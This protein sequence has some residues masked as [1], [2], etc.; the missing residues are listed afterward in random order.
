MSLLATARRLRHGPLRP[1]SPLWVALGSLF[2]GALARSPWRLA[3][4]HKLGPY[5]PFRLDGHFAFSNFEGWGDVAHNRGYEACIE[6]ARGKFCMLDV[7]GHI[8][9]VSL[10]AASVLAPGGQ[11]FAFEPASANLHYL[12]R[13]IALNRI[14]NIEVIEALVGAE[15]LDG[16][17]FF[18]NPNPTGENSVLAR[19]GLRETTRPQITLDGFCAEQGLAP[20]V[21]KIDV[22]GAEIDVLRGAAETLKRHRPLV[23][24]SVHPRHLKQL[25]R[26]EA[27]LHTCIEALGYRCLDMDGQP[28]ERFALDEYRLVPKDESERD[29]A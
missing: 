21:V 8:G 10:P 15:T 2:R 12:K 29:A 4:S 16:V 11:V 20:D 6:A 18:E 5:G 17:T 27:E 14:A 22:E 7:G 24:L 9:L 19:E 3:V 13:H 28:V 23:F 1:L 26:E 25:G